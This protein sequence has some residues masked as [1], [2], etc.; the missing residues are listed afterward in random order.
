MD[1]EHADGQQQPDETQEALGN[2]TPAPDKKLKNGNGGTPHL[3]GV[4]DPRHVS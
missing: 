1:N 3:G 2:L 4:E